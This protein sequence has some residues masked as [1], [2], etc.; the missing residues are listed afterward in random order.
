MF[1]QAEIS[2]IQKEVF[3]LTNCNEEVSIQAE[4]FDGVDVSFQNGQALIGC[5]SI[6]TLARGCL[7]LAQALKAG[8]KELAVAQ[9][10]HF[11]DCGVMLD[12]SRN[13]VMRV[14]AVKEYIDTMMV[15]GMNML[16]L[17]MEDVYEVPGYPMFGYQR[18]RYS[19]EE[20]K[21]IDSYA[22]AHGIQVIPCIQTLGHLAQYLRWPE[23]NEFR[24][25]N[26][27]LL[28]D[29]PKTYAFIEACICTMSEAFR[30]RRIHI[31]MDETHELGF[32]NFLKKHGYEDGLS[33]F[34]R[35]LDKV[36]EICK[37]Y[38]YRPMMWSDMFFKYV[39]STGE[40]ANPDKGFSKEMV[41]SIPDVDMVFWEY[42]R[43]EQSFYD[44]MLDH[45]AELQ[46]ETVFAGAIWTWYGAMTPRP[47]YTFDTMVPALRSCLEHGTKT[48][49]A[50][51]WAE[52]G[53]EINH[54]ES[55]PLLPLFSEYCYRGLECRE[56]DI[57]DISETVTGRA[58]EEVQAWELWHFWKKDLPWCLGKKFFYCDLLIDFIHTDFDFAPLEQHFIQG[59][60]LMQ[61]YN[62][63]L[64][65]KVFH[66]AKQKVALISKVRQAYADKD[67]AQLKEVADRIP[68]LIGDYREWMEM[69]RRQWMGTYKHN[70]FEVLN[71]RYGGI[72]AR[73]E[74]AQTILLAYV[75]GDQDQIE[76]LEEERIAFFSHG[77]PYRN[78]VSTS[79]TL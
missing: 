43:T 16:M 59:E 67:K 64:M 45:H 55:R 52:D 9:T 47:Q 46:K 20:L 29:E 54:M 19:M 40:Y 22:A 49:F 66:I 12:V 71:N 53:C 61:T 50:T 78:N 51:M 27:I 7:L 32:G 13:G 41:E 60:A 24:D 56:E 76:E 44:K 35:H 39:S 73:L 69:F 57:W 17:Y 33:I 8:K 10:Q 74:Y 37:K 2:R 77:M 48:V 30:S 62:N 42:Y 38:E 6:A 58:R 65:A 68:D 31:G 36:T 4:F 1:T 21:E 15:L 70:G 75:N 63:R 34:M 28:V 23:G 18:G 3:A 26:H 11:E 72:I 79:L 25:T 5:K 14:S